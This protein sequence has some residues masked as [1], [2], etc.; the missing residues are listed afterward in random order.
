[1]EKIYWEQKTLI[2]WGNSERDR[3]NLWKKDLARPKRKVQKADILGRV[4]DFN[5]YEAEANTTKEWDGMK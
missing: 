3:K 5:L 1:M 4:H 2:H